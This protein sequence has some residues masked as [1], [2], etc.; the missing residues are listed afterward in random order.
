MKK[1]LLFLITLTLSCVYAMA[2]GDVTFKA[3]APGTVAMGQQ[4]RLQFD[5]QN[6]KPEDFQ[7]PDMSNFTVL[8]GPSVS[9]GKSVSIVNGSVST[10]ENVA[11]TYV[12]TPSKEGTFTIS[13]ARF[14]LNGKKIMSN[15]L[16]IKVV[17]QQSGSQQ[18]SANSRQQVQSSNTGISDSDL[19]C[20]AEYDKKN[21]YEQEQ[22]LTTIK[23]YH[24]G[25]VSGLDN[26]KLPEYKGFIAQEIEVKDE[27]RNAGIESYNGQ[28]YYV[29]ILKKAILFPQKSGSIEIE[30]GKMTVVAEIQV[31]PTRRSSSIWDMDDF[32][33]TTQRVK[34]DVNIK[35]TK[36]EVKPLPTQG[37]PADF[38]N[39]VGSFK[40]ESSINS[41]EVKTNDAITL[42]IKISG[43]GNIKYAKEP[44][45]DFPSD[46]EVYDPKVNTKI[47]A[48]KNGVNGSKEIEYLVIPRHAGTYEIPSKSFSYFDPK[49]KKYTTLKTE[50][51]TIKVEKGESSGAENAPV[52]SNYNNKEDVKYL[53][54]DIRFINAKDTRIDKEQKPFFGTV[55]FYLWFIIPLCIFST[56]FILY[57]KQLKENANLT[58]V[59]NKRANKQATK[60][61]KKAQQHLSKNESE[62]FYEEVLKSLWGYTSDKLNIPVSELNN[63]NIET[64]LTEH[65][66]SEN[67][68]KEFMDVLNTCEYARFAPSS[69]SPAVMDELYRKAADVIGTLEDQIK[70]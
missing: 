12:L 55:G 15:A 62:A 34:K 31:R 70:K 9:S 25:N 19:F 17:A 60:R 49:T 24:K 33:G 47:N 13:P 42:K 52:V 51:Y 41:T 69:D 61:L 26:I 40:M 1:T 4:F 11:Y 67:V 16:T 21:V 56:L 63:D 2:G 57:R 7:A 50:A 18:G 66:V 5:I 64:Q 35:G 48:T 14:T 68:V 27:E 44:E 3:S 23:L 59:K 8:M 65:K 36:I 43:S 54:K 20:V 22:I 29:Y 58:L 37:R 30:P 45:L 53:G 6:A 39:A 32:F 38:N 28:R 10:T 46:F